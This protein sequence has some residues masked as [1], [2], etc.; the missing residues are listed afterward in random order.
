MKDNKN[1][2]ECC[3]LP[4][5]IV[6]KWDDVAEKHKERGFIILAESGWHNVDEVDTEKMVVR[7]LLGVGRR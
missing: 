5:G 7:Q 2:D 4:C 6:M 3:I 1:Y